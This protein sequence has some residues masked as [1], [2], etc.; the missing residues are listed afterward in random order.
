M[1]LVTV[2]D[3]RDG[4]RIGMNVLATDGRLV[5]RQGMIL[6]TRLIEGSEDYKSKVF[7]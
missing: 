5:L 3:I 7:T 6:T 2:D 4:D 1:R